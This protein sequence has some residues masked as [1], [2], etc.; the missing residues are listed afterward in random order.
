MQLFR[1]SDG[2]LAN[3]VALVYIVSAY[4]LSLY[5]LTF[6]NFWLSIFSV[7][8]LAHGMIISAYLIHECIHNSIFKSTKINRA[9][10]ITSAWLLGCAYLPYDL[11]K[12]K[13]L[14]HHVERKDVLSIDYRSWLEKHSLVNS[15]VRLLHKFHFPAVEWLTHWLSMMSPFFIH[16]RKQY[17]L[18][19]IIVSLS[20]VTFFVFLFYLSPSLVLGW[21]IAYTLCLYVLGFMDAY[22]HTYEI[23]LEL[24][25]P[26]TKSQ[27][28]RTY[29]EQNT[30]SNIHS[31][32]F[33]FLNL[34][35]L[36]FSYHNIHH[37]KSGEPWY[38]LPN[39][40]K[41]RYPNRCEQEISLKEQWKNFIKYRVLRLSK[42]KS[43]ALPD[44]DIGAA[45]V[46]FLV[47]I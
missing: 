41:E 29:E 20:R 43:S 3:T 13:H 46:S 47:A 9:F 28:D 35:T 23:A 30:Y 2:N 34:L 7:F 21:F 6:F 33:P 31:S 32:Q 38:R 26:R 16:S 40:H 44:K 25:L 10:G 27:K 4:A 14:R 5:T 37:W 36:N 18:R 19:A 8:F 39:I 45:G 22:Q 1:Y 11:L 42:N 12:E 15:C 24:D 17:R